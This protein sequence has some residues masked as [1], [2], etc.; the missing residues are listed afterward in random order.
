MAVSSPTFAPFHITMVQEPYRLKRDLEAGFDPRVDQ[1]FYLRGTVNVE[2]GIGVGI[3]LTLLFEMNFP[4]ILVL[5]IDT[6]YLAT[7]RPETVGLAIEELVRRLVAP[8]H[9]AN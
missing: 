7:T 5:E 1:S 6:N 9:G 2:C 3:P 8:S 4:D